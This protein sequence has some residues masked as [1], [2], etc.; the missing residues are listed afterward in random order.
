MGHLILFCPLRRVIY[1]TAQ[2]LNVKRDDICYAILFPAL[3]ILVRDQQPIL[4][5]LLEI[6]S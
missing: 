4:T 1:S 3:H 5:A 6:P 2:M